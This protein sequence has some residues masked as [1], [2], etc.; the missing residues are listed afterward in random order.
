V[1]GIEEEALPHSSVIHQ[2]WKGRKKKNPKII[3]EYTVVL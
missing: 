2:S 1:E 3:K